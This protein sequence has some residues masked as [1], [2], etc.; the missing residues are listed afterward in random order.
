MHGRH[1]KHLNGREHPRPSDP[2]GGASGPSVDV[3][4]PTE[5]EVNRVKNEVTVLWQR[6][7]ARGGGG[8]GG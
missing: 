3:A 7:S 8:R 5:A 1:S 4:M 2:T 6:V